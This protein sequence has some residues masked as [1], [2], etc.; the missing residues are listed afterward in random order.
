MYSMVHQTMLVKILRRRKEWTEKM[1]EN[2]KSEI[3]MTSRSSARR[4]V[5]YLP[6]EG[7]LKGKYQKD[8]KWKPPIS[9]LAN[10]CNP[11]YKMKPTK[12]HKE[13]KGQALNTNPIDAPSDTREEN[14]VGTITKETPSSANFLWG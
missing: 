13:G 4:R 7:N 5:E 11:I 6:L 2:E 9:Y 14:A 8:R 1:N 3:V 10:Q 12:L